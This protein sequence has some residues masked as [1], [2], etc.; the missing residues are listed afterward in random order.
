MF[1]RTVILGRGL[2]RVE[3]GRRPYRAGSVCAPT[4]PGHHSA[5]LRTAPD[6]DIISA[7]F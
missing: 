2:R 7:D 3:R 6:D 1:S 5:P 4:V